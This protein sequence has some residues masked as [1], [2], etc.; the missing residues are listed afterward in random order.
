MKK[1]IKKKTSRNPV[2]SSLLAPGLRQPHSLI[3]SWPI[4]TH[5]VLF[6]LYLDFSIRLAQVCSYDIG[7][8]NSAREQAPSHN[9][10]LNSTGIITCYYLIGQT[11]QMANPRLKAETF[12]YPVLEQVLNCVFYP[13]NLD[14]TYS[15]YNNIP[16]C[17][18]NKTPDIP[19]ASD[20]RFD[21]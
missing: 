20:Q 15:R 10:F 3:S 13:N 19:T 2:N 18:V 5:S 11:N 6:P 21:H 8:P 16:R 1:K 14:F 7:I 9:H 12:Y 4:L 17:V